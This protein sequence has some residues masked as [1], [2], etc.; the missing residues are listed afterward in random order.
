M[1]EVFVGGEDG[2]RIGLDEIDLVVRREAQVEARVAVDGQQV[3]DAFAGLLDLRDDRGV[4]SFGELVL[5]TPAFAIF[6]VPL[7]LVGGDFRLIGRHLL[8]D[9]F[10]NRKDLQ[11]MIAEDADVEFAAV[12]V[13]LGDDVVVVL[14][15]NELRRVP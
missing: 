8:E 10:A 11:A 3:V 1:R 14:L 6:L 13:F 5:Q 9:E 4:E 2:I 15:V 12:D 7:G